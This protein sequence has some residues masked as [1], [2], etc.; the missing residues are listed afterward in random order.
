[1][2]DA[3]DPRHPKFLARLPYKGSSNEMTDC[4][5]D[6]SWFY[7]KSYPDRVQLWDFTRPEQPSKIWEESGEGPYGYY[8]WQAGV[9][10]GPVLLVPQLSVLK[11][12]TVPRPSQ[13]AAGKLIW[14]Q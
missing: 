2:I 3:R 7:I 5:A 12:I 11:V 14:R 4:C 13:V 8:A 1:M 9:P 10:V 6:G